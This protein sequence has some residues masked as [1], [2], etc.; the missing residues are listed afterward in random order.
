M[1]RKSSSETRGTVYNTLLGQRTG[2]RINLDISELDRLPTSS[3]IDQ[4]PIRPPMTAGTSDPARGCEALAQDPCHETLRL[5]TGE[6]LVQEGAYDQAVRCYTQLL[7]SRPEDSDLRWTLAD[8]LTR[9]G[10][11]DAAL[12]Q[13]Q[14]LIRQ[15]PDQA[16]AWA[17]SGLT[18]IHL[19]QWAEAESDL[20]QALTLD[21]T[22]AMALFGLLKVYGSQGRALEASV[23]SQ[24]L[25]RLDPGSAPPPPS[26]PNRDTLF[27]DREEAQRQAEL[28]LTIPRQLIHN[29][30]DGIQLCYCLGDPWPEA[31]DHLIAIDPEQLPAFFRT[32]RTRRP[33]RIAYDNHSATQFATALYWAS[34]LEEASSFRAMSVERMR[35]YLPK[36]RPDFIQDR[37]WRILVVSTRYDRDLQIYA[38]GVAQALVRQGISVQLAMERPELEWWD[39]HNLGQVIDAFRPHAVFSINAIVE[40]FCHP[41]VF[42][43]TWW[44]DPVTTIAMG[45]PLPWREREICF[46]VLPEFDLLLK[47]TGLPTPPLR[48]GFCIDPAIFCPPPHASGAATRPRQVVMIG[49]SYTF[50]VARSRLGAA[51][52]AMLSA[53]MTKLALGEPIL[54][55]W[56]RAKA[57][58][59]GC[60][61]D[62]AYYAL[63]HYVL[64]DRIV[65]WLC[66]LTTPE[67]TTIYGEGWDHDPVI[68]PFWRGAVPQGPPVAAIYRE[69]QYALVCHP[70]DLY[71]QRILE[72]SACGCI[73]V[74]YDCRPNAPEPLA[75]DPG[76]ALWFRTREQLRECLQQ[77]PAMDPVRITDGGSYDHLAKRMVAE[78][79]RELKKSL[80]RPKPENN[81]QLSPSPSEKCE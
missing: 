31:P 21:G 57:Q 10:W 15:S 79:Q 2:G 40:A 51:E 16:R 32:T 27:L 78:M 75:W 25:D 7:R 73:P 44:Q 37:P 19:N 48:Q 17:Q 11:M 60:F 18:R 47:K 45:L 39:L 28:R 52:S 36:R 33:T 30:I 4:D 80:H 61:P 5:R 50:K 1:D 81:P 8:L 65:R 46:S 77:R 58:E 71:S 68:R 70:G 66:E 34:V 24:R 55:S 64:R 53:L 54:R 14:A 43:L 20:R 59:L 29:A 9:L 42:Q 12:C 3:A 38:G 63:T 22:L 6:R 67:Q 26:S 49:S 72:V 74:I 76:R 23:V 35:E 56:V 13:Y 62:Y 69:T 41:E